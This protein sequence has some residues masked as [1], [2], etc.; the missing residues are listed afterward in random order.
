VTVVDTA[1]PPA[2]AA[3]EGV[4]FVHADV[5]ERAAVDAAIAGAEVVV[6]AAFASPAAPRAVIDSVNAGG[7]DTVRRAA[8]A[9]GTRRMVLVSSTIVD[10][11]RRSH[12]FAHE[13][14]LARLD[15]YRSARRSAEAIVSATSDRLPVAVLRPKTFV[16]P[17]RVGGFA[18][19]M[20]AVRRGAS[21]PLIDGGRTSYQLLDVRD[22]AVALV[23]A[24]EGD[25]VGV[26]ALGARRFGTMAEDV[27][28]LIA[29]AGTG[30]RIRPL[31]R[32]LARVALR[33]VEVAGG[34][35]LGEWHQCAARGE[36]SV[37][38]TERAERL[39]GWT[40]RW[41]NADALVAA[42][43]WYARR[44]AAGQEAPTTH[45]VPA[46]HRLVGRIAGARPARA[47]RSRGR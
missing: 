39:L 8:I 44:V 47:G 1:P 37:V 7:T 41:S 5:R 33:A 45:A 14:P 4:A 17:G 16:G 34:V 11:R 23:R 15:A 20:D 12:P 29:H 6:H 43:D 32:T 36:A 27:G 46:L 28:A 26:F 2:W 22:L 31:P 9:A 21:V 38:S 10:A 18:L 25:A 42:Y 40:P 13:S 24:T 19:V 30:A 3:T 35:P